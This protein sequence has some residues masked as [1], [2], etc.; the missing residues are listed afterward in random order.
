MHFL[1]KRNLKKPKE[2][3]DFLVSAAEGLSPFLQPDNVPPVR[4]EGRL[5]DRHSRRAKWDNLRVFN[6]VAP[7]GGSTLPRRK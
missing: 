6:G 5:C 2:D 4:A 7:R 3:P 1:R